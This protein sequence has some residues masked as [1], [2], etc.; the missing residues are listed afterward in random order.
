MDESF[1]DG[2]LLFKIGLCALG[3][4]VLLLRLLARREQSHDMAPTVSRTSRVQDAIFIGLLICATLLRAYRLD[5]GIWFD[6]MLTYVN[7]M[8][9][10]VAEIFG[11]F[12]DANNHVLFS[13]LARISLSVFGDSVWA[14]RLPAAAFGI[15]SIAAL[16]YFS[17][18]VTTANVSLFA[19]ALMTF[20]YHH[21]WFSQNARGYTALLFFTL[22]SS[23][24]LLDA[25]RQNDR[26]KWVLY[27]VI[28]AL[29]AFAHLTIVFVVISHFLIYAFLLFRKPSASGWPRWN[30]L[31]FG[32]I[33]LGLLSFQAYA[34]TLPGMFGGSLLNS[35][36]QGDSIAWTNPIWALME[37]VNGMQIG[38]TNSGIALIASLILGIGLIDF[39]RKK[40]EVIGLFLIPTLLGLFL[41]TSIGYTLFPRFFFFAMGFGV[42]VVMQGAAVTG[43]YIGQIIRLPESRAGWMPAL[44]CVGIIAASLPSLRYVYF[45]KQNFAAAIDL[46]E[47]EK[48]ASDTVVTV[49]IAN[50]PLNEYYKMNWENVKTLEELDDIVSQTS[51]TWLVYTMPVHARSAYPEIL[52]RIA[53]D[54]DLVKRFYGTLNGGDVIVS[55]EKASLVRQG[56]TPSE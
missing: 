23:A 16:Y 52:E 12:T 14:F 53:R 21:I 43:Q 7:Y 44:F 26:R 54:Y 1:S 51:R 28:A 37:L 4:Y 50:F 40:P 10:S 31:L 15:G 30:G 9:L 20:S 24:F 39:M 6:E 33:P 3:L 29:G 49:G 19:A 45:P 55:L 8:P 42:V 18:R 32:F 34:L 35:G 27:G 47:S 56:E 46:I 2:A 48:R 25:L 38:F 41:M 13:I 5:S 17:R 11:T 22:L 36:L